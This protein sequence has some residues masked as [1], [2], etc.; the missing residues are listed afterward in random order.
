MLNRNL[1]TVLLSMALVI[2]FAYNCGED[3]SD[4]GTGTGTGTGSSKTASDLIP[5]DNEIS[6]WYRDGD[7]QH[8]RNQSE[9]EAIIDGEATIYMQHGF[10]ELAEQ[11][12][13]GTIDTKDATLEVWVYD[14]TKESNA[15]SLYDDIPHTGSQDWN[16]ADHAGTKARY[17][18]DDGN[19][20]LEFYKYN[21]YIKVVIS[22]FDD[23]AA[24]NIAK[25]F[26]KNIDSKF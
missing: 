8:A 11:N 6:K 15:S 22:N 3:T 9:L 12:F 25:L 7:M 10:K 4:Q 5:K 23:D 16:D 24:L 1:L 18:N 13:K 21:F 2:L 26:A 19:T 20:M 17:R 14:M